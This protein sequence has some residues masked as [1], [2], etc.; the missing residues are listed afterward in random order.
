MSEAIQ[1]TGSN[2]LVVA[3]LLLGSPTLLFGQQHGPSPPSAVEAAPK[4]IHVLG[5]EEIKRGSK[6]SL[7]IANDTLQFHAGNATE[8]VR[9]PSIQDVFTGESSKPLVGGKKGTVVK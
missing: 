6:G 1:L 7:V 9:I 2:L 4:A 8:E 5:L 3:V